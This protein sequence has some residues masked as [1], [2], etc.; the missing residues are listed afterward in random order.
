MTRALTT[1]ERPDPEVASGEAAHQDPVDISSYRG[2][3]AARLLDAT[4]IHDMPESERPRER[5]K[6]AGPGALSNSE[7]IAILLRTGRKGENVLDMSRRV[8][9]EL[10]G[11]RGVGR[12]TYDGLCGIHGISDA[13]ACQVLAALEL[14]SRL[15][16]LHP[17]DRPRINGADDVARI[18]SAEMALLDQEQLRVLLLSTKNEVL[19]SRLVYKG[20]VN[21]SVVRVAEVLRPAVTANHPSIIVVHNHP[22]GDPTPSP[23][24]VLITNKIRVGAE[25]LDVELLDHVVIGSRGHVSMKDRGLGFGVGSAGTARR[26]ADRRH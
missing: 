21:S 8:L 14:G 18:L 23:E 15:V 17:E 5:L 7:L 12:V 24:D 2:M 6:E 11:L 10:D 16:S 26:A 22:S 4:T 19:G 25:M 1:V 13:K 3:V 20:N 9:R